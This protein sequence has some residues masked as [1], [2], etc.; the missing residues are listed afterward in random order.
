MRYSSGA[1]ELNKTAK[2]GGNMVGKIALEE[3]FLSPGYDEYWKPTVGNV[4][5]KVA[6]NLFARLTDFGEMRLKAMDEAGIARSVLAIAGPGVQ[7]EPDAARALKNAAAFKRFPC[8]RSAKAAGPLFRLCA[9]ADAG[10]ARRR[11]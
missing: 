5:P 8:R 11:R 4:D 7:S 3:H 9:L 2:P 6:A 10:S 1:A